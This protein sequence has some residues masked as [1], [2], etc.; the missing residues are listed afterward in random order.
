MTSNASGQKSPRRRLPSVFFSPGSDCPAGPT[1]LLQAPAF[2]AC[3]TRKE[4]YMKAKGDGLA[5]PL[6]QFEV[7]LPVSRPRSCAPPG[8]RRKR[9][10]GP[11][12]ISR[13][14]QATVRQSRS[15]ATTGI[16]PAGMGLRHI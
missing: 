11:C 12:K 5:L 16:S 15:L 7:S 6:D 3:W 10:A 1:P 4:A 8:T 13:Q 14:R 9:H 2:F